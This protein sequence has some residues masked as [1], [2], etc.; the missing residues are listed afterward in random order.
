MVPADVGDPSW[1]E[2]GSDQNGFINDLSLP[3]D[4]LKYA[5][6]SDIETV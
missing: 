2:E 4:P 5:K 1:E 3:A 6:C